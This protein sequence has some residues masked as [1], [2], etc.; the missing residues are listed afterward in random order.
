M[1][2]PNLPDR[3]VVEQMAEQAQS[4]VAW[5][6][7]IGEMD[8]VELKALALEWRRERIDRLSQEITPLLQQVERAVRSIETLGL[9]VAIERTDENGIASLNAVIV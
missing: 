6:K 8:E 5:G 9:K 4:V 2:R 3:T 7:P 1:P